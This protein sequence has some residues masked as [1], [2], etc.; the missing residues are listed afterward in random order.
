MLLYKFEIKLNLKQVSINICTDVQVLLA[1]MSKLVMD[2]S[3]VLAVVLLQL[4]SYKIK[5]S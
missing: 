5:L 4:K 1:Q 3:L 2:A